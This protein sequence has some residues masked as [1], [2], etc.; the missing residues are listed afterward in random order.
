M[1]LISLM[2]KNFKGL[3]NFTFEPKGLSATIY[4]DNATGK[5]T[6]MDA[7]LWLLFGKTVRMLQISESKL[8]LTEKKCHTVN[9][10]FAEFL[11][12]MMAV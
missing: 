11:N 3:K 9:M 8:A 12:W 4:G 1:K 7:M 2:L 5:T 6:V 10:K